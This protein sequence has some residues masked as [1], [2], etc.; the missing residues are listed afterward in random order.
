MFPQALQEFVLSYQKKMTGEAEQFRRLH[1][2]KRKLHQ[3]ETPPD[4]AD[5]QDRAIEYST[6]IEIEIHNT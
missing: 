3:A 1:E 6:H 2:Q 4:C 5:F